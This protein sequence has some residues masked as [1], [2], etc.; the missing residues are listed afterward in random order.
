[1]LKRLNN[2]NNNE[3]KTTM[4]TDINKLILELANIGE[5]ALELAEEYAGE[6]TETS[7]GIRDLLWKTMRKIDR[8]IQSIK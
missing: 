1:M 7:Q 8:E 6:E 3:R 4:K 5:Q 2:N